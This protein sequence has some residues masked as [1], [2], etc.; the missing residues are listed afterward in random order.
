MKV[1]FLHPDL[2]L[3]GAE[4]LIVDAACALLDAGYDVHI[5]TAHHDP[6]RSFEETNGKLA[7]RVHV[8]GDF[9]PR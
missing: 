2:G 9:I 1:T 7:G 3:G 8:G 4:R 6:L 5:C